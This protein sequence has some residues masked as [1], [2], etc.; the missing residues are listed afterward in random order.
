LNVFE[1]SPVVDSNLAGYLTFVAVGAALTVVVGRLLI[2]SGQVYL[3]EAFGDQRMATSANR[4]LAVLFHLVMLGVLAIISTVDVPVD[5][6]A[7]AVV[8]KLGV[9]LLVLGAGH[10]ATM[11]GLSRLRSRRRAQELWGAWPNDR[12]PEAAAPAAQ[13]T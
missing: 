13:P 5:G 4:L 7:Q 12:A 2:R 6:V 8:T 1:R 10:G 3:E 11:L 9:V